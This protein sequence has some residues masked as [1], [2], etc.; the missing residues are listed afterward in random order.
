MRAGEL[1]VEAHIESR[2]EIWAADQQPV[3]LGAARGGAGS[4]WLERSVRE[5]ERLKC[6]VRARWDGRGGMLGEVESLECEHLDAVVV[7]CSAATG[8]GRVSEG[9]A[10]TGRKVCGAKPNADRRGRGDAQVRVVAQ[11]CRRRLGWRRRQG[12]AA[13]GGF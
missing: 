7:G 5:F 3:Q 6:L 8:G 11:V 10:T 13:R 4:C 12:V 9:H 1:R 2:V